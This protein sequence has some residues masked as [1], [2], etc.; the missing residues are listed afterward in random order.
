MGIKF[1]QQAR[2]LNDSLLNL[3]KAFVNNSSINISYETSRRY[4]SFWVLFSKVDTR[5]ICLCAIHTNNNFIVRSL[6]NANMIPRSIMYLLK[7]LCCN[8]TLSATYLERKCSGC[9]DETQQCNSFDINN[10]TSLERWITKTVFVVIKN[11]TKQ[12]RKTT[13]EK[14]Q[15]TKKALFE[16]LN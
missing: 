14:E 13:K 8:Y 5:N 1:K 9:K 11:T 7:Y 6:Y 2:F 10:T 15:T 16:K 4:R 3:H 12:C